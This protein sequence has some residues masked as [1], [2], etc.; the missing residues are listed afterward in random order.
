[1][2]G[3]ILTRQDFLIHSLCRKID[4]ERMSVL[5]QNEGGIRKFIPSALDISLD[6]RVSENLSAVGDGFPNTSLVLVE[7]GYNV[8]IKNAAQNFCSQT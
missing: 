3:L 1:M 6:A 8:V 2:D 7:H 5:H 4:D